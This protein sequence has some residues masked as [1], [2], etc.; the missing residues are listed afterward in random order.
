V[1]WRA[2]CV[3]YS[4]P[5]QVFGFQHFADDLEV[6]S[7]QRAQPLD[8]DIEV[9]EELVTGSLVN[10]TGLGVTVVQDLALEEF[11]EPLDQVQV[12]HIGR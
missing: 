1:G 8:M 12:G 7:Q 11:P 9:G 3:S 2:P 5:I 10:G 4:Q 6:F